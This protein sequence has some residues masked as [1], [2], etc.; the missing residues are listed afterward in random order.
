MKMANFSGGKVLAVI[1]RYSTERL[2]RLQIFPDIFVRFCFLRGPLQTLLPNGSFSPGDSLEDGA[3]Y[4][5][6]GRI[7]VEEFQTLVAGSSFTKR[8]QKDICSNSLS[9][10]FWEEFGQRGFLAAIGTCKKKFSC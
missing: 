4:D 2:S 3:K 7:G 8:V 5:F 1:G 10:N 9:K 6:A